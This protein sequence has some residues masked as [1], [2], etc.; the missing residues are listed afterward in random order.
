[1]FSMMLMAV[2]A[3]QTEPTKL[4]EHPTVL[5]LFT[6]NNQIRVL[7]RKTPQELDERLCQAA[8]DH[9]QYMANNRVMSH[10]LNGNPRSRAKKYGFPVANE[11]SLS[12]EDSVAI[13]RDGPWE[14]WTQPWHLTTILADRPYCGFGLAYDVT[15][16]PYWCAVYGKPTW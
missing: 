4:S 10:F 15:G 1:M 5:S 2:L 7:H 3:Q 6:R 11:N 14:G 8:Q 16:R 13:S 12:V 9:A